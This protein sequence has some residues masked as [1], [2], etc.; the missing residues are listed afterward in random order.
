MHIPSALTK[1]VVVETGIVARLFPD[2]TCKPPQDPAY[3]CQDAPD[4]VNPPPNER[5]V[6]FPGHM[7]SGEAMALVAAIELSSTVIV[8]LTQIVELHSPSALNM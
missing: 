4:P 3:H 5:A 8:L 6:I 1:Y 7:V 2:P